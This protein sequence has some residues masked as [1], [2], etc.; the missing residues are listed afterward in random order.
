[1]KVSYVHFVKKAIQE[2]I[3]TLVANVQRKF[4]TY[5]LYVALYCWCLY[6]S[7]FKSSWTA[8]KEKT[9]IYQFWYEFLLITIRLRLHVFQSIW[10]GLSICTKCLVHLKGQAKAFKWSCH[11][12][13]FSK[14]LRMQ[15][16]QKS[17][18]NP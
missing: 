18:W 2:Q 16:H 12:I 8:E 1:M 9:L 14:N 13:A 6:G 11:M 10:N 5:S 4:L 7:F 15:I 17:Y 3:Y